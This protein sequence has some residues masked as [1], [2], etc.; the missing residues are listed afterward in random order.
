MLS[1]WFAILATFLASW[2]ARLAF[3]TFAFSLSFTGGT[4]S[5]R[6]AP[7]PTRPALYHCCRLERTTR[8]QVPGLTT[9]E[10]RPVVR[11]FSF[12]LPF[13]LALALTFVDRVNVLLPVLVPILPLFFLPFALARLLEETDVHRVSSGFL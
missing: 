11:S 4:F 6:V 3:F 8:R 13:A 5:G 10:A 2:F 1:S 7:T 9:V 12:A